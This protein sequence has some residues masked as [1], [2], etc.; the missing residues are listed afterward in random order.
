MYTSEK[1]IFSLTKRKNI[2]MKERENIKIHDNLSKGNFSLTIFHVIE[3]SNCI[4]FIC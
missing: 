2:H 3:K 4:S 1:L